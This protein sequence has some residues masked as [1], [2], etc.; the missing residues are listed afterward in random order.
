[1]IIEVENGCISKILVSFQSKG[2]FPLP[3]LLEKV[4]R[5]VKQDEASVL[6]LA[7]LQD[8]HWS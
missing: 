4:W 2:S 6:E 7:G 8:L 1:M 3:W 5:R